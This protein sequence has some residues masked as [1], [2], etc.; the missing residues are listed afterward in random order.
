MA[1]TSISI[2]KPS[3]KITEVN[4]YADLPQPSV[5][6]YGQYFQVLNATG[7]R[8]TFNKK[9]PGIYWAGSADYVFDPDPQ[10]STQA[11]VNAGTN[12]ETYVTPFTF[13]NSSQIANLRTGQGDLQGQINAISGV[14][15]ALG[16]TVTAIQSQ[17]NDLA[18]TVL[19]LQ[20]TSPDYQP[21][22]TNQTLPSGVLSQTGRQV[23]YINIG[24]SSVTISPFI[25]T[26]QIG[27]NAETESTSF[28]LFPAEVLLLRWNS[29]SSRWRII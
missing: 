9:D 13:E 15:T 25:P 14:V 1:G 16:D 4:T 6:V 10:V 11:Q 26:E 18:A 19:G 5:S 23:G 20:Q 8:W 17:V 2:N 7:S 24:T 3:T 29:A 27:N 22:T 28:T 12:Q 21:V